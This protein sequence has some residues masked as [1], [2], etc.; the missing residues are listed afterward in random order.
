MIEY[1][2]LGVEHYYSFSSSLSYAQK[3][4]KL[5]ILVSSNKYIMSE[6][7]DGN[8]I[9]AIVSPSFSGLQTRG[10]SKVTGTFTEATEHV[11]FWDSIKNAFQKTT[12][13]LGECYF[14]GGVDRFVSGVLRMKPHKAKSVQ[15]VNFYN[16]A[17]KTIKFTPK[18]KRDIENNAFFNKKLKYR[19][20]DVL[21]FEGEDLLNKPIVERV[22]YINKAI[23]QINNPLV[24]GA[25][26][27]ECNE[28]TFYD[29]LDEILA[30]GGEGLVLTKA[31]S[32]YDPNRKSAQAWKTL[33]CKRELQ[34]T[35][36]AVITN[37]IPATK[38]Y[39]GD[40]I[41]TCMY[42]INERTNEKLYGDYYNSYALGNTII[43]ISKGYYYGWCG[44]IEC[45][46]YDK[47]GNLIPIA[48]VAGLKEDFKQELKDNFEKY[49]LTPVSLSGM[50]ISVD[51]KTG[52]S[53]GYSIRH[54]KLI[55]IRT[56]INP[57]DCTL[58][59]IIH[60]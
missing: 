50:M 19:I 22:K 47:D 24:T 43:P 32:L 46:V 26:Y 42:W 28:E 14:D 29:T 56:D 38:K 34:D 44:A 7:I 18:D 40:K 48:N 2:N 52:R 60:M 57:E 25:R 12:V 16:E 5:D 45:S 21:A 58:E 3:K 39:T 20:F 13:L 8:F 36:D 23:Q 6:K 10:I 15:D 11:F 37:I 33:K 53:S 31:D 9:R 1:H 49:Y 59:K 35:I 4:E 41:E 17:Q 27:Q 30:K 51:A 55:S 54:P